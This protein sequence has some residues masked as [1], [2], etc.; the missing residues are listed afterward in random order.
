MIKKLKDEPVNIIEPKRQA[1][2]YVSG[3]NF[4]PIG[5]KCDG[6]EFMRNKSESDEELRKR[7]LDLVAWP[8]P[9]TQHV[10]IPV[11]AF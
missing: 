9:D 1:R 10:F 8:S 3:K 11:A 2:F 4:N 6:I 7:C 5:Y